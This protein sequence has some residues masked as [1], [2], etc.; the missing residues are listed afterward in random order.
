MRERNAI[1]ADREE[2]TF[3]TQS[4]HH[5]FEH[6]HPCDCFAV[7]FLFGRIDA[8]CFRVDGQAVQLLLLL[9]SCTPTRPVTA[10]DHSLR[11][12]DI[13]KKFRVRE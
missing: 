5:S 11:P 6:S 2:A 8:V 12:V 4:A 13:L 1:G 7:R 9:D 3:S 10:L